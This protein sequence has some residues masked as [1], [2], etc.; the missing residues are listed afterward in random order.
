[1]FAHYL[2]HYALWLLAVLPFIA[3]YAFVRFTPPEAN[4]PEDM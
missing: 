4:D 3:V 2:G 1:M